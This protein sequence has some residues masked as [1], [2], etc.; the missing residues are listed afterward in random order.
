MGKH[1]Q[2]LDFCK[3]EFVDISNLREYDSGGQKI[4]FKG[5]HKKYGDIVLKLIK[6]NSDNTKKRALRELEI[7]KNLS[8]NY[9]ATV[10]SFGN[11]LYNQENYMYV[12]EEFIDGETLRKILKR[13]TKISLA[14]TIEI[15]KHLLRALIPLHNN[16]LVHRDIKPENIII[17]E[18]GIVLLDFGIARALDKESLTADIQYLG[19]MTAGYAAPEQIK[20]QKRLICNRT[21]IFSWGVVMYECLE[22]YNPFKLNCKD[23]QDVIHKSC[24]YNPQ[25]IDCSNQVFSDMIN[26]ALN[27]SV[28]RRPKSCQYILNLLKEGIKL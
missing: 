18:K 7:A 24:T 19:P 4:I 20:N 12:I 22:G 23:I 10:Y 2:F 14:E 3:N 27:K 11:L 28:H 13:E 26:K 17:T 25:K 9:Y 16:K 8:G 21:D 6:M 15:G 5:V 1:T